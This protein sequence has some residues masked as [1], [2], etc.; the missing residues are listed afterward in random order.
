[1][2]RLIHDRTRLWPWLAVAGTAFLALAVIEIYQAHASESA[3]LAGACLALALLGM[4]LFGFRRARRIE[5]ARGFEDLQ[6][7]AIVEG[8][9]DHAVYMLD[10]DGYV[11]SW[12]AGAERIN[13]YAT[14]EVIGQHFLQFFTERDRQARF[15]QTVLEAAARDGMSETEGWRVR[16]DGSEFY[17]S[18]VV[19]AIRDS[20]GRLLGFATITRD[21]TERMRQQAALEQAQATLA[22]SMKM[23]A[24]GQLTGGMAHDFNNVLH[25]IRNSLEVITLRLPQL[26]PATR[27]YLDMA[28]RNADGA[29]AIT[30]RL[31]AYARQQ[32]LDPRP[33]DPAKLLLGMGDLLRH[34][35]GENVS[36]EIICPGELWITSVDGNQLETAILNLAINAR[37]AMERRGK[38][39]IEAANSQ[40]DESHARAY[41]EISPGQYVMIAVSDT[42]T[43][44]TR[45]VMARA[46]DPF[47][48]TKEPGMGTGL[49][50]SQV[51]GFVRQSGGHVTLYSEVGHGTTVKIY[52]PRLGEAATTLAAEPR[53]GPQAGAGESI[54]VVEDHEDVR[55]F[56]TEMLTG[57][58]YRVTAAR[59]GISALSALAELDDL[60]LL[61]T[62]SGL[63]GG[64]NGQQLAAE[65]RRRCPGA[66][67]LFTTAYP[68]SS[69][70]DQA[71]LDPG[72]D[73]IVKPYSQ[74]DLARKVRQ[75]L[76][77]A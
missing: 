26:D 34:A 77:R 45:E 30:R 53:G 70:A 17:S 48:T 74:L 6:F 49:G 56:A 32:P 7:R 69:A 40:L 2:R 58:G 28:K 44:M 65:V 62:D 42:G 59:D 35:L 15:P 68:R 64:L 47:F 38:L 18:A 23:E 3:A 72:L 66:R 46:F 52:L 9:A 19:T 54:L 25:V 55:L 29:A 76:D 37:D 16:K 73:V 75:V 43:G 8:A 39:I 57:L 31:L 71:R 4:L 33:I 36:V 22:Q 11:T 20:W 12:N 61:F 24:L 10:A 67:V 51:V 14:D 63:P 1:M 60:R 27:K 5:Q 50:L 21:I 13:G 41:P